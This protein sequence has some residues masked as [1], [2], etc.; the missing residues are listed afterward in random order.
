MQAPSWEMAIAWMKFNQTGIICFISAFAGAIA[1]YPFI[2]KTMDTKIW[3]YTFTSWSTGFAVSFFV[4][5][6]A[7]LGVPA[8]I[9][10]SFSVGLGGF[11][12]AKQLFNRNK[13]KPLDGKTVLDAHETIKPD[14]TAES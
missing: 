10:E 1:S 11:Y 4:A 3:Q 6:T 2:D 14:D 9:L 8:A 12:A 13:T 5:S 7:N